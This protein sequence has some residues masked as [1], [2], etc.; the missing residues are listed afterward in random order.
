MNKSSK[1]DSVLKLGTWTIL[2]NRS[3]LIILNLD[4][5]VMDLA[6]KHINL[7]LSSFKRITT[8]LNYDILMSRKYSKVAKSTK[9]RVTYRYR[10][11]GSGGWPSGHYRTE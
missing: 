7:D 4:L 2:G 5:Q 1:T 8:M 11:M 10:P 6:K 9:W 3:S